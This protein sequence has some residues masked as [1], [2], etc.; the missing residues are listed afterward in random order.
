M[1]LD[2]YLKWEGQTE[3]ERQA[4][5]TGFD[6]TKGHVGYLRSSYCNSAKLRIFDQ[7]FGN[8]VGEEEFYPKV[9][10]L[11]VN[12]KDIDFTPLKDEYNQD[13]YKEA[14]QSIQDFVKLC[15][16]KIV[17]LGEGKVWI[18]FRG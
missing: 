2:I 1:G 3:E 16:K 7:L 4:Q 5:F 8:N 17:E 10:E 11:S 13:L 6:I 15:E 18:T 14:V 12:L 9:G